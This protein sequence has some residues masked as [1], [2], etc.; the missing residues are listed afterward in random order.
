F[1]ARVSA[2]ATLSSQELDLLHIAFTQL[3]N[4][5]A[6]QNIKSIANEALVLVDAA[7]QG[8]AEVRSL[9]A[10]LDALPRDVQIRLRVAQEFASASEGLESLYMDPRSRFDVSREQAKNF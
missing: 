4:S 9:N 10:S 8:N 1:I 3:A 7:R 5:T 2:D 6:D